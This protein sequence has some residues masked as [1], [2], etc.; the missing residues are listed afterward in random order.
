MNP[1]SEISKPKLSSQ[2]QRTSTKIPEETTTPDSEI[3]NSTTEQN[4]VSNSHPERQECNILEVPNRAISSGSPTPV[5]SGAEDNAVAKGKVEHA[6]LVLARAVS[7]PPPKPPNRESH[8]V[9]LGEASTEVIRSEGVTEA[10][11]G[12]FSTVRGGF[13]LW[14]VKGTENTVSDNAEDG[15]VA[16]VTDGGLRTRR[17][18]QFV[19][20]MP[21]PL[22]T[23]VFP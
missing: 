17:L 5:S 20:L 9:T 12:W 14:P 13:R 21:P 18:R 2:I 19:S 7:R 23:A 22:L 1:F 6:D 8:T 3:H 10:A 15:A 11:R 16:R 4:A